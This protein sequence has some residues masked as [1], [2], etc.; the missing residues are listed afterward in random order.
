VRHALWC[1]HHAGALQVDALVTQMVEEPLLLAEQ[2][3]HEVDPDLVK[4]PEP[5]RLLR[6]VCARH[7]GCF[8]TCPFRWLLRTSTAGLLLQKLL[9]GSEHHP[10]IQFR[11]I[12]GLLS[13][14]IILS[15]RDAGSISLARQ[16]NSHGVVAFRFIW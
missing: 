2:H 5:D 15:Q 8:A 11:M 10:P 9:Q 4:E 3:G 16:L 6:D 12:A 7:A 1:L 13:G 14:I